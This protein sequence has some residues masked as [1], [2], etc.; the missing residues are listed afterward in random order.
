M[1]SLVLDLSG[2]RGGSLTPIFGLLVDTALK[3][4]LLIAAAAIVVHLL[5]NR[6]AAARHAAW[7]AAVIGHLALPALTLMMPQWRLPFLPAPPWLDTPAAAAVV[8]TTAPTISATPIAPRR[9]TP[10]NP[11]VADNPISSP[12]PQL[13]QAESTSWLRGWPFISALGLL[14]IVGCA[15]V[16]LRLAIGTWKVGKLAKDG[17]RVD[18]GEWLSLAQRLANRLG[19][20][21]PLTL[22]RG[23]SLAVPVTWGV[24]YPA[25]LLPPDSS[26]WPESRRRFVLVH[27]IAHVKRFD[28]LT[29][30]IAQI[31]VAML[32]FDPFIWFAVSRMRVEREHACD[33]YVLREGTL[34]SL[35][36][37]ELLEMVQSIGSPNH[38]RAAPAFAALAMARRSEFEGRMLAILDTRQNRHTLGR[39]SAIA[40]SI[41]LALLV[42]P[43]AALRPFHS[44][45]VIEAATGE[46]PRLVA[47]AAPGQNALL[48]SENACDSAM[49]KRGTT[50]SQHTHA[51][52][53]DKGKRVIEFMSTAPN[54]CSQAA[55]IGD[56]MFQNDR[57]IGL[58]NGSFASLREVTPGLIRSV[59]VTPR[60]NGTMEFAAKVNDLAVPYDDDMR[61][62]FATL[63]PKVL[64][65]T[66]IDVPQR[67][68]RDMAKGGV[69]E[70]LKRIAN[71]TST[72]SRRLHYDALLDGRP[73]TQSEYD[74]VSRHVSTYL[75]GS[76]SDLSGVL[77]RLSAGPAAGTKSLHAAVNQLGRA[78]ESLGRA[79][80]TA[81]DASK[82]SN[83]SAHM[84]TQYA[85]T[86]D[87]EMTLMALKGAK[88]I[89]S[90]TDKRVFLQTI[91]ANALRR[92]D[93]ALRAAF[94]DVVAS[95]S[96][97]TDVRI[98]LTDALPY[99]HADSDVTLAVLKVVQKQMTSDGD[100][101]VVLTTA[102]EQ[103]LLRTPEVRAAFMNA[104]RAM[105]SDTEYSLVMRAMFKQPQ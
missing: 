91:A 17:D 27:E 56:V 47:P 24:V 71:I 46:T 35:Y 66:G 96:S 12:S 69:E 77:E 7:T 33:D 78:Q 98:V 104:A 65:E 4:S 94:F 40:A 89:S 43:L 13:N 26:E 73:L 105:T 45:G 5:K 62:W 44:P 52:D 63:L 14:W 49:H 84:L 42:F 2:I 57:L 18:D 8:Q 95:M 19:I 64:V 85:V 103:H 86:D 34:P 90:D 51:D 58:G 6:S 16:L 29:Q 70:V 81:L 3:G 55:I 59:R 100:R 20:T 97:D 41:A 88:D 101:R 1:N 36:A 83:D 37:G 54:H 9:E 79:L 23:D 99:G 92:K 15:L 25:V 60:G 82:S 74:R 61:A 30:L 50:V 67:V 10:A 31:T 87:P 80:R 39:A 93:A 11:V 102:I 38:D 21:R 76:P 48:I 32:W 53:D 75:A 22:L 72:A 68:A 28:A